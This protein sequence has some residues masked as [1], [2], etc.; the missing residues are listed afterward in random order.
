[1]RILPFSAG[2]ALCAAALLL[3]FLVPTPLAALERYAGLEHQAAGAELLAPSARQRETPVDLRWSA[4]ADSRLWA[5][6]EV[7]ARAP[8]D[9]VLRGVVTAGRQVPL[10]DCGEE[11]LFWCGGLRLSAM[12][13]A[14]G[15]PDAPQSGGGQRPALGFGLVQDATL[16]LTPGLTLRLGADVGDRL[17]VGAPLAPGGAGLAVKARAGVGADL[18]QLGT[19]LPV[20]LDLSVAVVRDLGPAPAGLRPNDCEGVLDI[21]LPSVAPLRL[22]VPCGASQAPGFG[23]GLRGTF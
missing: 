23:F 14:R 3:P 10:L 22:S 16:D 8:D 7:P 11:G 19:G 15:V 9:Q 12:P 4:P 21:R 20:K 17:G 5:R 13:V 2:R 6:A 18:R 1:M